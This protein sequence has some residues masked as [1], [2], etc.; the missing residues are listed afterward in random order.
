MVQ[1]RLNQLG[2][3][4][5]KDTV[6]YQTKTA[7]DK[8]FGKQISE[9][10][11]QVREAKTDDERMELKGQIAELAEQALSYYDDCMSGKV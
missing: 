3:D 2:S 9:L 5:Y 11:K 1:D 4:A 8:L 7:M 6:E 10:N